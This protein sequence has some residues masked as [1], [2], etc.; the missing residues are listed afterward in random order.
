M[1]GL[2]IENGRLALRED[3]PRPE[4]PAG[5]VRLRTLCAGICSTDLELLRGYADFRGVPGHEFVG[6]VEDGQG[7]WS[8]RRVVGEIN[9]ACG[10]CDTCRAGRTGHCPTRTVLGIV[11]RHGVFAEQLVLPVTN[12]YE[13]PADL[14]DKVAV[15]TE[16]LA[17]ALQIQ[18]QVTL[19]PEQKV[20]VVGSGR[21]GQLIARTLA[22]TGCHLL[23]AGRNRAKLNLLAQHGTATLL[24]AGDT[25]AQAPSSASFDVVIECTGNPEGFRMARRMVRPGGTLVLKS[26]YA[27]HLDLDMSSLVVDEITLLGS[28]CGPFA[29]ALQMLARGDIQVD[30]LVTARYPL[31]EGV[32]AFKR[33]QE[34]DALKVLIT[35]AR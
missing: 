11:N 21:L 25:T 2:W 23:V 24:T 19:G 26:T 9:A 20:L 31:A 12:L 3:L 22:L 1:L 5:E 7:E 29:P 35:A 33:A 28:R 16:P 15:F 17:A 14:P 27:D 34:T 32:E 4:P 10:T 8:G 30:D 6:R 13:V 18:E